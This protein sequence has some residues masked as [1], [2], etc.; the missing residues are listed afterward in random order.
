MSAERREGDKT[1]EEGGAGGG[2]RGEK[3]V[4]G[5][6]R[7]RWSEKR[8]GG[9]GRGEEERGWDA[10]RRGAE[11]QKRRGGEGAGTERRELTN[12]QKYP[13]AL[14][15]LAFL[16]VTLPAGLR[17]ASEPAAAV[18]VASRTC[19]LARPKLTMLQSPLRH[20]VRTG[21]RGEGSEWKRGGKREAKGRGKGRGEGREDMIFMLSYAIGSIEGRVQIYHI[22][23]SDQVDELNSLTHFFFP[24][25]QSLL[26]CPSS[27]PFF[28]LPLPSLFLSSSF[29]LPLFSLPFSSPH[30][31]LA[32]PLSSAR[33]PRARTSRSSAIATLAIRFREEEEEGDD[34]RGQDIY[35]VNAIVFHKMHGTFCTGERRGGDEEMTRGQLGRTGP[36]TS[37]IR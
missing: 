17:R 30:S 26:P 28:L 21:T 12:C 5:E 9:G 23:E 22:Q 14:E 19:G 8:E 7:R 37:G 33:V 27:L 18:E 15:L 20:Q 24:P 11:N 34:R 3:E 6:E 35:A 25:L 29:P 10:R 13:R 16:C 31:L 36:S 2:G 32:S 1:G 4:K